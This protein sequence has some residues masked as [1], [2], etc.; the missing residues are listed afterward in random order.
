MH[1]GQEIFQAQKVVC[2]SGSSKEIECLWGSSRSQG[3]RCRA[4]KETSGSQA[5]F[6]LCYVL[7]CLPNLKKLK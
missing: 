4:E 3:Q 6:G 1:G 5:I 2:V 7:I